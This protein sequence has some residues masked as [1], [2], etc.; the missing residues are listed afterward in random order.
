MAIA[1]NVATPVPVDVPMPTHIQVALGGFKGVY[2][3]EHKNLGGRKWWK[4]GL[5]KK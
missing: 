3:R 4:G 5:G 2:N 1:Y